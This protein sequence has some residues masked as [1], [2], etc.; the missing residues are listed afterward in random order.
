MNPSVLDVSE[1]VLIGMSD[2]ILMSESHKIGQLWQK[3]MPNKH[4][5][6]NTINNHHFAVQVYNSENTMDKPFQIWATIEVSE[7]NTI[8][9]EMDV[10]TIPNGLYAKFTLRG[11][12]I[13]RLYQDIMTTWLPSS[14]YIID[15]RPHFQI[16]DERYKNN[17]TSSEE[18]VYV[19]IT[20]LN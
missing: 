9:A 20:K 6:K 15:N 2:T 10:V 1:K 14:G 4:L 8:P 18:D 11:M 3:F 7:A 16:M 5:I 17:S 12:E 19:P 13:G